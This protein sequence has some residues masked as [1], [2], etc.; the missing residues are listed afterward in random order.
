MSKTLFDLQEQQ[1]EHDMKCHRDIFFLSHQDR[2][3]HIAL[4][5][6]KYSKRLADLVLNPRNSSK[7]EEIVT[8]TLTDTMIMI[9][10]S[11]ELLQI[12]F[13]NEIC[14]K[15]KI[16]EHLFIEKIPILLRKIDSSLYKFLS[17]GDTQQLIINLMLE[18]VSISGFMQKSAEEL[19]HLMG[20][21][22]EQ[23]KHQT[24]EFLCLIIV[25]G[26]IWHVCFQTELE[27]RWKEIEQK[28]I[29]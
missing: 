14:S 25:A 27:K 8:K 15:L 18:M 11:G 3:K 6:G 17:E 19:D 24:F 12:N 5:Y 20:M 16:D 4:H 10:N 2:F 22:R 23:I 9:L 29:L 26:S 7:A 28:V 13:E 1:L 21:P